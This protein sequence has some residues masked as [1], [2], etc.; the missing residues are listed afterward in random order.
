M[1]FSLVKENTDPVYKKL[2]ISSQAYTLGDLAMLQV[3]ADAIDVVPATA[4]TTTTNVYAV[5]VETVTSSATEC[6]FCLV[7]PDQVWSVNTTNDATTDD[8]YQK[9]ILTN[10][11]VV[12]NTHT[13]S[14]VDEAV[15]MQTGVIGLAADRKIV[16]NI[17]RVPNVTA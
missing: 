1:A 2:R 9:M 3:T 10:K 5:A 13:N 15:F 7:T 4:A 11:G 6:L 17:L 16:G 8:N 14:A 12:N